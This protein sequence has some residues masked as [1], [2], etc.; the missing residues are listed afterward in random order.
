[1]KRSP[2]I[3]NGEK[4]KSFQKSRLSLHEERHIKFLFFGE[5]R[6]IK[7]IMFYAINK[8]KN[9]VTVRRHACEYNNLIT[10]WLNSV[11]GS[12]VTNKDALNF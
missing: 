6:N 12:Y 11:V 10:E 9:R 2:K 3:L 1:M 8:N 4:K 5:E 7:L